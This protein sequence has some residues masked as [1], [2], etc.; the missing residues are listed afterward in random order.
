MRET[1]SGVV[2]A[3]GRSRRMGR[4]KAFLMIDGTTLVRRQAALLASVGCGEILISGRPDVDYGVPEA[5]IVFDP[6]EDGGPLAGLVAALTAMKHA[7]LLALAVDL[8]GMTPEFLHRL[9]AEGNAGVSTVPYGHHG[10]EPMGACY[11]PSLGG[12]AAAALARG[13]LSLQALMADAEAAGLVR[14][15]TLASAEADVFE[16]WN[17]PGDVSRTGQPA[18][19]PLQRSNGVAVDQGADRGRVGLDALLHNRAGF[20]RLE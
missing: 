14:R 3:G 10:Y 15:L 19:A 13:A 7:R 1:L 18:R 16:N 11:A 8:P 5:R 20:E 17:L 12:P 9:L 6:V 2:L 4:D